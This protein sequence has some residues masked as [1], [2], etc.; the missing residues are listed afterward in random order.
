MVAPDLP[1][2]TFTLLH[3]PGHAPDMDESVIERAEATGA[4]V[5]NYTEAYK[6]AG[7]ALHG[8]RGSRTF[9]G[10]S[11]T[12]TRLVTSPRG[13]AGDNPICTSTRLRRCRQQALR[14]TRPG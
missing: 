5:V 12:N 9:V 2:D 11:G 6:I 1:V 4:D 8:R 14:I 3:A 7:A 13:D 10:R